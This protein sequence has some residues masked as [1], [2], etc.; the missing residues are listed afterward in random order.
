MYLFIKSLKRYF[1][2]IPHF[3]K[4]QISNHVD[5]CFYLTEK[6]LVSPRILNRKD[7]KEEK[8]TGFVCA[9]WE[10]SGSLLKCPLFLSAVSK[11]H[12]A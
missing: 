12:I 4:T 6:P 7:E 1:I 5:Y 2:K 11:C 10:I 8:K 9:T 3:V